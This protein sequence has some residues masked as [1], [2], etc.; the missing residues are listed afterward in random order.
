[1]TSLPQTGQSMTTRPV[2]PP[3][4]PPLLRPME[5]GELLDEAFELYRRNFRLFFGIT[6][7]LDLPITMLQLRFAG[8]RGAISWADGLAL[9]ASFVTVAALTLAAWDRVQGRETTILR[10]Y[11]Q[12]LRRG[13]PLLL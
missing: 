7:L 6:V 8:P 13:I 11:R 1:M 4:L 3:R 12:V 2:P 5:I 10:A 9:A